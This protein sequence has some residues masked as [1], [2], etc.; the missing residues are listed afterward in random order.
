MRVRAT[1]D[2]HLTT[3][4]AKYVFAALEELAADAREH[5]GYTVLAGDIFDQARTAHMPT[6]QRLRDVLQTWPGDGVFVLAGNHDQYNRPYGTILGGLEGRSC[7]VILLPVLTRLGPMV[8]YTAPQNFKADCA[9]ALSGPQTYT[10]RVAWTHQGFRGAYLNR[11]MRDRHGVPC[12]AVPEEYIVITGHYHM[13]QVLGPIIYCGSPY[14]ISFAEEGQT[15]GWLRWD[16]IEA[17]PV[18]QRIA[19]SK[20]GAPTHH[21]IRWDSKGPLQTPD[22]FPEG[23]ILRVVTSFNRDQVKDR[24]AELSRRGLDGVPLLAERASPLAARVTGAPREA[25][26]QYM[27]ALMGPDAQYPDPQA[28]EDFA[29]EAGLWD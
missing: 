17:D 8:P 6:W 26:R 19:Y 24:A 27:T 21:T 2:L 13:P 29:V 10:T 1:S 23:S 15:K 16:D 9:K 14:Q 7:R 12:N 4:S 3:R 28:M 20:I 11:L 25:A 22:D 18:P 5:G